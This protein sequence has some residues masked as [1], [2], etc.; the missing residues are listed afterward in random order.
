MPKLRN[1]K[2]RILYLMKLLLER[3]DE[4]HPMTLS[5]IASALEGL[6]VSASRKTLY[7]DL[8]DLRSFG[9]DITCRRSKTTSYFVA[10]RRFELPELKLLADAVASSKFITEKKSAHLIEKLAGLASESEA[11][12]LQ[13]QVFVRGRVKTQNEQI[14]YN[15]DTIHQAVASGRPISFRYF[16]SCV[17]WSVPSHWAKRFRRDGETYT[18]YPYALTWDNE[19]YYMVAYYEKYGGLSNFR[20]DRMERIEILG[21]ETMEKPEG[22]RFDA[23]EYAK[24]LFGMFSG[25]EERVTLRFDDSLIGV[26][27]DRFGTDAAISRADGE[28]FLV[29]ADVAVSPKLLSWIFE[30]GSRVKIIEPL[31]LVEELRRMAEESLS[32][33][34]AE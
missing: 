31:S 24:K 5:E 20:V 3:T 21:A 9:I 10:N 15:V 4:E 16:E 29:T 34:R 17:D 25:K 14:Y 2:P 32:P 13:R 33:Y 23:A 12:T 27:L 6:G 30:Y 26:V 8:E 28:G 1:Q 18:A 7:G 11:Q 22:L 19:N